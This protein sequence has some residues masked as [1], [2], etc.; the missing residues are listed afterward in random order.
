MVTVIVLGIVFLSG[1]TAGILA[2]VCTSIGSEESDDSLY[3]P[4]PTKAAAATRR[5]LGWH[6]LSRGEFVRPSQSTA[7]GR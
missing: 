7:S 1:T 5:L 2:L 4:P 6:G 3:K